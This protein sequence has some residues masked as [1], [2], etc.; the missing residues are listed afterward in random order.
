MWLW[1]NDITSSWDRVPSGTLPM[2]F[3]Y[4]PNL[5]FLASLTRDIWTFKLVLFLTLSSS[6]LIFIL[7]TLSNSKLTLFLLFYWLW[8]GHRYSTKLGQDA[9]KNEPKN[10][11]TTHKIWHKLFLVIQLVGIKNWF[12]QS[13][14]RL[15]KVSI[16]FLSVTFFAALQF[17]SIAS[18]FLDLSVFELAM[19]DFH[20]CSH[21]SLVLRPG[22]ICTFLIHSGS[23]QKKLTALFRNTQK[24]MWTIFFECQGKVFLSFEKILENIS[25]DKP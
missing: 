10:S 19:Q 12:P 13:I 16:F 5:M 3:T 1:A 7:L 21:P 15:Q 8:K 23:F 11:R 6:K 24:S 25:Q 20:R 14:N 18:T 9:M 2:M 17:S 22:I 4:Y